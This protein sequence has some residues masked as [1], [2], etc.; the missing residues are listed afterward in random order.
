LAGHFRAVH[1]DEDIEGAA[2]AIALEGDTAVVAE[3]KAN[4]GIGQGVT[5]DKFV[6]EP[7]FGGDAFEE[8]EA[9]GDVVE[10]VLDSDDGALGRADCFLAG[11][12]ATIKNQAGACF[13]GASAADDCDLADGGNSGQGF[14]AKAQGFYGIEVS[15]G[16]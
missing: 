13:A 2:A 8:F 4:M 10:E 12:A 14:T 16:L 6:N 3:A 9:G 11:D 7:L 15:G 1:G 5:G